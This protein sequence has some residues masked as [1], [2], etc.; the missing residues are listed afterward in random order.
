MNSRS[1]SYSQGMAW[2]VDGARREDP[3][4]L[5]PSRARRIADAV[6][7]AI[8]GVLCPAQDRRHS[9]CQ[10]RASTGSTELAIDPAASSS[11]ALSQWT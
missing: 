10:R 5:P 9:T 11:L 2:V 7:V 3:L 6:G 1:P 8:F 4:F